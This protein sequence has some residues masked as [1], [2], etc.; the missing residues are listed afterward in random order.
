MNVSFCPPA[1][2]PRWLRLPGT[3]LLLSFCSVCPAAL[4]QLVCFGALW[5]H[6]LCFCS[7]LSSCYFIFSFCPSKKHLHLDSLRGERE[8]EGEGEGGRELSSE[9]A[10]CEPPKIKLCVYTSHSHITS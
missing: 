9:K 8:E 6:D 2:N 7:L 10:S 3:H 5:N 1:C 4:L